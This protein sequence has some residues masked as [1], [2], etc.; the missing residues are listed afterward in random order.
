LNLRPGLSQAG[1]NNAPASDAS[2]LSSDSHAV[3]PG[4]DEENS[5][6]RLDS[7]FGMPIGKGSS[8][9]AFVPLD[10]NQSVPKH[11][12]QTTESDAL[13]VSAIDEVFS[14]F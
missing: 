6:R 12:P 4:S 9:G 8:A 11:S 13:P 1:S 2:G 10:S 3:V 14:N 5:T 7:L